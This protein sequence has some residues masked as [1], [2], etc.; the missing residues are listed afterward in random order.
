MRWLYRLDDDNRSNFNG[1]NRNLNNG[2]GSLF[3]I[4]LATRTLLMNN[5]NLYKEICNPINLILAW[6]KARKHKTK[7]EYVIDFEKYLMEKLLTLDY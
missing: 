6:L 5:N 2:N 3:G 7:K 4:A 1:N